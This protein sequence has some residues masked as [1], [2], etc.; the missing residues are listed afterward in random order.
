MECTPVENTA[1]VILHISLYARLMGKPETETKQVYIYSWE[2]TQVENMA[3]VILLISL[4]ARLIGKLETW[5]E[6]SI[7]IQNGMYACGE[8]GC[9]DTADVTVCK[10]DG[11][12]GNLEWNKYTYTMV[13]TDHDIPFS[14]TFQ[15]LLRYIFKEFSRT[16]LSNIHSRKYDQQWTSQIRHAETI[17]SWVRQKNGGGGEIW[18]CVLNFFRWFAVLWL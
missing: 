1:S 18:V 10:V 15:G 4:Y 16:F 17:W 2:W 13:P 3:S 5:R 14:R 9:R 7:H 11:E 6:T 8:Y 12:T